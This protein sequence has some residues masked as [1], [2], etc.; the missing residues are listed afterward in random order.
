MHETG[1]L[2]NIGPLGISSA[3][4][5]MLIITLIISIAAVCASSRLRET[6]KG[7]QNAAEAL[8][9]K[10]TAFYGEIIGADLVRRYMPLLT[11]IFLFILFSNYWGIL[12]LSGK[13][14]GYVS[15]TASLSVTAGLALVVFFCTHFQGLKSHGLSYGRHFIKPMAI[16]LPLLIVEELV[17]PVS[18]SLRLYGNIFGEE[19]VADVFFNIFPLLL[20]LPIYAL[21][22]LMGFIQALLFGILASVY[23]SG[24]AGEA[25]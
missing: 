22:L 7:A 2:F 10:L 3:M 15:P 19:S 9:E 14:P 24:A 20:P 23:I 1:I 16:M 13:L 25:H 8:L 17:R 4:V 11:T 12:P 6:P 18:L 5:S 21:S